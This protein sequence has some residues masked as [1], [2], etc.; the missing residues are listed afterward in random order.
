MLRKLSRYFLLTMLVLNLFSCGNQYNAE[1]KT[2]DIPALPPTPRPIIKPNIALVLGGGGAR[3]MA[4][5]GVIS[6]LQENNIP[7][8]LVVGTSIGSVVG[9]IYADNPNNN[10]LYKSFIKTK[11]ADLVDFSI[12][13]G[14]G[15]WISGVKLEAFIQKHIKAK[16][17]KQLK[18][19]FVAVA[20][21]LGN[22]R[23]FILRSGPISPAVHASSAIAGL[24]VPVSMYG[25]NLI[26]GGFSQPLPVMI[27]KQFK[28]KV[29][30]AVNIDRQLR[31]DYGKNF[32]DIVGRSID[33]VVKQLSRH[34][35]ED[36][37][38][39]IRPDVEQFGTF[40]D[41][42]NRQLYELGRQA[43]L[44]KMAEIRKTIRKKT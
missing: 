29:I 8:D 44:Q 35:L 32:I 28:P 11:Q 40:D 5:L 38:I 23:P 15:G 4:H 6:V 7:V 1:Q 14:A 21:D 39:V 20:T 12:L 37:D 9:A 30:I 22:G 33:I 13:S 43:A 31:G 41:S 18:I 2:G 3:G 42:N 10:N 16:Y 36:A 25:A 19:P 24:F 26:D 17:F 34:A 27:A